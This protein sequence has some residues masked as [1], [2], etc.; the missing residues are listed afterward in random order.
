MAVRNA[1]V[2][3][4]AEA[5]VGGVVIALLTEWEV[6]YTH[7]TA[8]GTAHGDFWKH[9]YPL[10]S[11]WTFRARGF[12]TPGSA[13]HYLNALWTANTAAAYVVVAGFSGAVSGGT[14]IFQGSG[15]PSRGNLSAPMEMAFQEFEI[16]GDGAPTVGA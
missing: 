8:D 13:N 7:D 15:L 14:M 6:T 12:V 5:S 2:G 11:Q 10:D 1:L 16:I 4:Y 3:R 9:N